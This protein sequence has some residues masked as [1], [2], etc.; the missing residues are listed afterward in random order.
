MSAV[1][2][3][4]N[5]QIIEHSFYFESNPA[6][7]TAPGPQSLWNRDGTVGITFGASTLTFTGAIA[8]G[9][10]I[11]LS[12]GSAAAPSLNFTNS[13]T[14]GLYR[15]AANQIGVALAGVPGLVV[16]GSAPTLA[17]G[18]DA[19]GQDVFIKAAAA[20]ATP[21]VARVGGAIS[22]AAGA[23]STA[24][25]A[26][27]GGA[28]GALTVA[29]GAGGGTATG[30]AGAGGALALSGAA[31]GV[32]S[33]AGVGGAGSA[34]SLTGGTGG[35]GGT[36]GGAGGSITVTAGNAGTGGN[37]AGGSVTISPGTGTG[38]G[39][40]GAVTVTGLRTAST[41]AAAITAA[42][43][44][45][46][47]DSGGFFTASQAAAYAITLPVPTGAGERYFFSLTAPGANVVAITSPV[48]STV[49]FVGTIV[50]DVT[51]V[52]PATANTSVNFA[53]GA[54]ILG[55]SIECISLSTTL[56]H[57]RAVTSAASGITLT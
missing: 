28:G 46:R 57:V 18:A 34:V 24:L 6:T 42:R 22:I 10:V 9:G 40:P 43:V 8:F 12:N 19:V 2:G 56:Y 20:G 45:T 15:V 3:A 31:G 54:A 5:G 23:G 7:G 50:N 51:S 33:G 53:S 32:A 21:T 1:A 39:A 49:T 52:I 30:T 27:T 44:L 47:A 13:T 11:A 4:A 38:T 48:P 35:N 29:P 41:S 16:A 37:A 26:V 14:T 25:L 36:T 55:D 17:A